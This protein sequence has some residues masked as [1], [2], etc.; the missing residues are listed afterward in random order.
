MTITEQIIHL[1]QGEFWLFFSLGVLLSAAGFFFAFRYLIRAR[2]IQDTPTARVR[3][4]QQGYLELSGTARPMGREA[5]R[6]PLTGME[7]CWFRYKIERKGGKNWSTL[8]KETSDNLFLL[9][10]ET[11]DCVIDPDGADVTPSDRNIWYGNSRYPA[12]RP[13]PTPSPNE[14]TLTRW[15]RV[16]NTDVGVATRYRYTEER[17]YPGD[18]I[19]TIG[20]FRSLDE[21]DHQQS[22]KERTYSLLRDWKRDRIS[23]LFR[24]DR[25]RDGRINQD[26][27]EQARHAAIDQARQEHQQEQTERIPHSLGSTGSMRHP[28]LLSSMPQFALVKRFRVRAAGALA[29]FFTAG[30][31]AALMLGSRLAG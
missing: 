26:E 22:R 9:R 14:S 13:S 7:C 10:D 3:S 4:A 6:A 30:S 11:G 29:L 17:I 24:F 12:S 2:I 20:L 21:I 23:L 1:S 25:D 8:E 19:Y 18:T 5:A 27:W 15:A 28:F 31:L 16:L